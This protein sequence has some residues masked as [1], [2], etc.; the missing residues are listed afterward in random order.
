M[1]LEGMRHLVLDGHRVVVEDPEGALPD[2]DLG[3][4][5]YPLVRS[6]TSEL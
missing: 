5:S 6:T 4:G 1:V 2:P 3:N